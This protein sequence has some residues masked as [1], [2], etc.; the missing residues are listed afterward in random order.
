VD[1]VLHGLS[2]VVNVFHSIIDTVLAHILT[3]EHK[4]IVIGL[5]YWHCVVAVVYILK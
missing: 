4:T 3:W 5:V 2:R 1:E